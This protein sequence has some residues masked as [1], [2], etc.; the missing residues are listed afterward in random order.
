MGAAQAIDESTAKAL[1]IYLEAN[2]FQPNN[3]GQLKIFGN[4]SVRSHKPSIA[5]DEFKK[6]VLGH[7]HR[8]ALLQQHLIEH[9]ITSNPEL[10]KI[11]GPLR[12]ATK[13]ISLK[14]DQAKLTGDNLKNLYRFYELQKE[15]LNASSRRDFDTIISNIKIT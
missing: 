7:I 2:T 5:I 9:I 3:P 4:T 1:S 13:E 15:D 12:A 8:V 10:Q 14:H 11:K 6:I